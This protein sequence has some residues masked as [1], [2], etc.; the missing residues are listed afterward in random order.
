MEEQSEKYLF[1]EMPVPRAVA[2]LAIPT[3]ISQVVTMIYNLADTFFIGQIG[4][5]AMVAAV[6]LVS[7]WFNLLTAIGN[8]FGLGG[9]SLISRMLGVKNHGDIKHVAVFSVWGGGAFTLVFSVLTYLARRP[10]LNFLGASPDTF[11]YAESYLFWVVVLGGVPTMVSLALGHLLRSEGHARQASAGMMF[12]GILNVVLDPI[13]IFGFHMDVAGAAIATAFS[14][15]A[16]V[17]FFVVQYFRL[18][19]RTDVSLH[20]KYFTFRF[21]RQVFS[22]GLASALATALGNASNMVMV[23][24]ASGYGDIP[25]AAYGIVKRIDQFPLNV[26]MGLCQG[27]MP[28]VGYNYAAKKYKRMRSVSFFSWKAAIVMSACFIACFAAFAPQILHLFIPEEQTSTLGAQF[29]RIA[30]LAVPLTSVNFLISYTLQAMGKGVQSAALTFSRQGLLNIPLL[31]LMNLTVGLYG[32][33]WTQLVV[34]VIKLPVSLG[35][36]MVTF[37]KLK[38]GNCSA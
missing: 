37:R 25:V 13:L 20:P 7:P 14:N 36:Y 27:F 1:E 21:V 29:L 5:P 2:T 4:D 33:I 17:V 9:S 34:E 3:I 28:L 16:S 24:L 23:R 10:L 11:R 32:M 31:I 18:G 6:S 8:L 19:D 12:G 22:V 35:M 26:S 30:C 15:A 38:E